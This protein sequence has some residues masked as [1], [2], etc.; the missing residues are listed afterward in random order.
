MEQVIQ[1][2]KKTDGEKRIAVLRMEIDYEL[3]TLH[4]AMVAEDFGKIAKCKRNLEKFRK[5]LVRL[6]A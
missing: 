1:T 5:E 4:D 2:F 3:A 6:E